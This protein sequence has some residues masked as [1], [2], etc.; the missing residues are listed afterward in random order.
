MLNNLFLMPNG[1]HLPMDP[2]HFPLDTFALEVRPILQTLAKI[3][4]RE[5]TNIIDKFIIG[6]FSLMMSPKTVFYIPSF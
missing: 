3:L 5:D 6:V 2:T 1:K 4:G